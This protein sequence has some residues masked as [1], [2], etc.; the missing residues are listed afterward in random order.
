MIKN[1]CWLTGR[2]GLQFCLSCECRCF[3]LAEQVQIFILLYSKL[4][5]KIISIFIYFYSSW[6]CGSTLWLHRN[7]SFLSQF[8]FL[9]NFPLFYLYDTLIS[10]L[11][12]FNFIPSVWS[13]SSHVLPLTFFCKILYAFFSVSGPAFEWPSWYH[14]LSSISLSSQLLFYLWCIL[15]KRLQFIHHSFLHIWALLITFC[16][17]K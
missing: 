2:R 7:Q 4:E 14:W 16:V 13:Y 15:S 9:L 10:C 3:P 1:V 5:M 12:Y 17:S 11:V 6:V 8:Y